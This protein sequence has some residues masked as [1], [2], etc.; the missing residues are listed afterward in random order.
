MWTVEQ[1]AEAW[2]LNTDYARRIIGQAQGAER[3]IDGRNAIWLV[4]Q[5]ATKPT[6]GKPGP[7]RK[8]KSLK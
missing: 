3:A 1:A 7:K 8:N 5:G 4:P 6:D 2:D